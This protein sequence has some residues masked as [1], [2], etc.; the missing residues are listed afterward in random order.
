[1]KKIIELIKKTG[2]RLIVLETD[3]PEPYVVMGLEDYEKL[4][5]GKISA[6]KQGVLPLPDALPNFDDLADSEMSDLSL[7][8]KTGDF[9]SEDDLEEKPTGEIPD[10]QYYFE[11]LES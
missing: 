4:I 6:D 9:L 8:D 5:D 2:D 11:P 7:D 10:D 3:N 1:M